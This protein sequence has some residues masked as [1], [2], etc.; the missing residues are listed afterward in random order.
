ML[1]CCKSSLRKA[2]YQ[3]DTGSYDGHG[4]FHC[5]ACGTEA[6]EQHLKGPDHQ[7]R[8]KHF[9]ASNYD[10][11]MFF[12]TLPGEVKKKVGQS[13]AERMMNKSQDSTSQNQGTVGYKTDRQFKGHT[14]KTMNAIS[15]FVK[16]CIPSGDARKLPKLWQFVIHHATEEVAEQAEKLPKCGMN[17]VIKNEQEG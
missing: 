6:T 8:E 4:R 2:N 1:K 9:I 7:A 13:L 15:D 5:L 16:S 3:N 14:G 11:S 10:V 17:Y 12:E